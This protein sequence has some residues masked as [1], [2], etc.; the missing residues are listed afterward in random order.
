MVL[1]GG[2]SLLIKEQQEEGVGWVVAAVLEIPV[3]K[4]NAS[5]VERIICR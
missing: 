5:T 4:Y 2:R 3:H 1:L